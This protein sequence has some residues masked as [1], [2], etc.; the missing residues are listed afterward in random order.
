MA[1]SLRC[2][3][4]VSAAALALAGDGGRAEEAEVWAF[5]CMEDEATAEKI[6]TTELATS[7]NGRDF[8]IYFV[9]NAGG[10]SPLVVSGAERR[11]TSTTVKVDKKDPVQADECDI[12]LCY[13][14]L[15]K[16]RLLLRQFRKGYSARIS[17]TGEDSE[18]LLDKEITLLGFSA[19]YAK[20]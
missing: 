10:P 4:L 11:L 8:L 7:D 1:G 2:L 17:V 9:H 18:L 20:F 3:A 14:E 12:G 15:E 13:F 16:S 6:C 5:Q 19:A